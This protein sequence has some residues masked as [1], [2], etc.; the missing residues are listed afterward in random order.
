MDDHNN[1]QHSLISL[2]VV[3]AT[4]Y[5]PNHVFA[6]L[7]GVM[8]VIINLAVTYFGGQPQMRQIEFWKKLVKIL[9]FN[10]Y[11]NEATDQTPE[12]KY[13][14]QEMV[15]CL[16]TLPRSKKFLGTQ[17]VP[18]KSE[19]LQHKCNTCS[20]RVHTYCLCSPG[21]HRCAEWFGYHLAWNKNNLSSPG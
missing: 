19:Y 5:W 20:K 14:Q 21:V 8:E 3:W 2:E 16:I 12:K 17:I 9:I 4:K 15:H 1:K 13:K 10:S 18:A 11:Y 6:F 7:L